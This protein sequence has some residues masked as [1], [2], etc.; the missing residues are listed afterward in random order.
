MALIIPDFLKPLNGA[1][2]TNI[3]NKI[4]PG[5]VVSSGL[6]GI[7]TGLNWIRVNVFGGKG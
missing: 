4:N 1:I 7:G 3:L 5:S 2:N 6:S